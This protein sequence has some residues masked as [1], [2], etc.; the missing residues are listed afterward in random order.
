MTVMHHSEIVPQFISIISQFLQDQSFL[1]VL[2]RSWHKFK[3]HLY[4]FDIKTSWKLDMNNAGK[5]YAELCIL[6]SLSLTCRTSFI[7]MINFLRPKGKLYYSNK[8]IVMKT[9]LT[10]T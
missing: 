6:T 9:R 2:F 10:F 1:F 7:C 4:C 3:I 5:N 8:F